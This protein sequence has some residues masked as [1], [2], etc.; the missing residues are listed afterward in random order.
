MHLLIELT[1]LIAT[2]ENEELFLQE[3]KTFL[4]FTCIILV[5]CSFFFSARKNQV[6][7]K[8]WL[9]LIGIEMG[10][11]KKKIDKLVYLIFVFVWLKSI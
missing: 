7:Q 3:I 8:C 1:Y 9:G 11:N 6:R 10:Q 2:L 5:F 4:L